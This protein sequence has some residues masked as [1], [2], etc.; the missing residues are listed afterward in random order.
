MAECP[1]LPPFTVSTC[2][3]PR[4]LANCTLHTILDFTFLYDYK[5]IYSVQ[6]VVGYKEFDN[7]HVSEL[8]S[9]EQKTHPPRLHRILLRSLRHCSQRVVKRK[10]HLCVRSCNNPVDVSSSQS[11]LDSVVKATWTGL[12]LNCFRVAEGGKKKLFLADLNSGTGESFT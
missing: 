5:S 6:R 11:E 1:P 2:A 8:V 12:E 9:R 4:Q 10:P 7:E 3:H